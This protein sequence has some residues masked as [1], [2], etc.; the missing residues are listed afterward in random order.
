MTA[1]LAQN[2]GTILISIVLIALVTVI[3]R[4]MIRDKKMGKSTC[5]GSCASCKMCAACRPAGKSKRKGI[6]WLIS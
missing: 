2:L 1:W 3:I 6:T 5:G 4:I